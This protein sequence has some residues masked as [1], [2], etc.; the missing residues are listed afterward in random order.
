M[1]ES[2]N[3]RVHLTGKVVATIGTQPHGQGNETTTSQIIADELG[4]PVEDITVQHSD[5]LGTPFGL[6]RTGARRG[7][8]YG[9]LQQPAARR[10]RP[11]LALLKAVRGRGLK[12]AKSA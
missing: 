7:Q 4:I 2:A 9:G 5:T 10:G 1:W 12:A 3:L 6:D 11:S 8:T